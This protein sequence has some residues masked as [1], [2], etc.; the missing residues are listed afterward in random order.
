MLY[1]EKEVCFGRLRFIFFL[2]TFFYILVLSSLFKTQVLESNKWQS[3]ARN[4]QFKTDKILAKRGNIVS[5]DGFILA[6]SA[7]FYNLYANPSVFSN[8]YDS[9]TLDI[10]NIL[11]PNLEKK[12]KLD[13]ENTWKEALKDKNKK[14]VYLQKN[15]EY[16]VGEEI[17]SKL[18]TGF[19]LESV[20]KRNYPDKFTFSHILG[21]VGTDKNG[22]KGFFGIEG[23]YDGSLAGTS[24]FISQDKSALGSPILFA[25]K[26][27]IEPI[28]GAKITL[29]LDRNIQ[30]IVFV[31]LKKAVTAYGAKS[32]TAI[33]VKPQTGEILALANY[34]SYDAKEYSKNYNEDPTIFLNKAVSS[35]YEPGSV[36]KAL[37]VSSAIDLNLFNPDTVFVDGGKVYYGN[38]YID[39]WDGKH[40]G[41]ITVARVLELSNNIG[42]SQIGLKVGK[43]NLY[44]YFKAF[45]FNEKLGVD[46]QGEETGQ[47]RNFES[48]QD[49]DLAT[50]S[51]GQGFSATP[52]QVAMA[53]SAIANEGVLMKPHIVSKIESDE[54]KIIKEP[55]KIR[56]VI[57]KK[58]ATLMVN[59]LENAVA[60][61]EAQ[62]FVSKK[63]NV[64]GKTGTA[65]ISENGK[66][67]KDAT[68][69]TFVGFLPNYREFVM[70]V[71][72]E[73]PTSST[74]ASETAVPTWMRIAEKML[75]YY[76]FAPDKKNE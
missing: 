57:T 32:A 21:F 56:Q 49:L 3:V 10:F 45:S 6:S 65:Q 66:Y 27:Q 26:D 9:T 62:F 55:E 75:L 73:R 14:F 34:P 71:K 28:N 30:N 12:E 63:Y 20:V 29:T 74:Y 58:S 67:L 61:G 52:L 24:G 53:F 39:N 50:A 23:M 76:G 2:F 69:A 31:E 17:K 5:S 47:I 36:I 22:E 4:Q 16:K 59:L 13:M 38:Y 72:L 40:H 8:E 70:L 54:K 18:P 51:F 19:G 46:L 33:V 64:A 43:E 25:Q 15:I 41:E 35:V 7:Y 1:T 42:A 37:T 48:W 44:K 11:N 68:N 60:K